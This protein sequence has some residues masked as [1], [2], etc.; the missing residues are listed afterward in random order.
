M[1]EK[2]KFTDHILNFGGSLNS[3]SD[4]FASLDK[5]FLDAYNGAELYV[6]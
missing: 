2:R 3:F 5:K 6:K 4:E 1:E